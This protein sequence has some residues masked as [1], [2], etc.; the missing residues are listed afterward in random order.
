MSCLQYRLF[1]LHRVSMLGGTS[2]LQRH[3]T[4]LHQLDVV[5]AADEAAAVD[6]LSIT[7]LRN[8]FFV[9]RLDFGAKSEEQLR[10]EL[11][12]WLGASSCECR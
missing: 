6:Q 2:A 9:R 5:M 4:V 11:R 8:H 3:A 1:K 10:E 7:Q 12:A